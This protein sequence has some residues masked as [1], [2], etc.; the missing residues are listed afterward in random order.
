MNV[1]N[2]YFLYGNEISNV[3]G[4]FLVVLNGISED[5]RKD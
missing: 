4:D 5:G 2:T 1:K 3:L